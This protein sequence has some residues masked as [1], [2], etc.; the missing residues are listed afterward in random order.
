MAPRVTK[1]LREKKEPE[2]KPILIRC[3][4]HLI[5]PSDIRMITK[6]RKDLY[7]VKFYSDPNPEYPC[8]LKAEN[9]NILLERFE[10]IAEDNDDEDFP[11]GR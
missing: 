8:W 9:I 5:N 6:V 1:K 10:I 3:G 2:K 11:D 4:K 7:I